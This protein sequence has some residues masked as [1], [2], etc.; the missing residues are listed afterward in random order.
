ML[1]EVITEPLRGI[2]GEEER[3][4]AALEASAGNR[5]RAA[6]L[7]GVSRTTLWR[8]MKRAGLP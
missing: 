2:R 8:R 1:Y 7:L 3:L 5:T 6:E 4:R